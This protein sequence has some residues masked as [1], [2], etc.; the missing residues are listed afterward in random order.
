MSM[1][2]TTD[3]QPEAERVAFW[4]EVVCRSF[5]P[6]TV[7]TPDAEAF[8]GSVANDRLG[9]LQLSTVHAAA[10]RVRR[11]PRLVAEA[12][13][14]FVLLGLQ[15]LG[16]GVVT[17]DGRRAVIRPGDLVFY[18]AAR[19]YELWF[20]GEFEM[21][22]FMVP[23]RFLGVADADLHRV[24][25]TT[26]RPDAG[27]PA[28]ASP[29]L[30]RLTAA[31][32]AAGERLAA[33]ALNL[34]ESLVLDGTET[35]EPTLLLRIRTFIADHLG[36]RD[37]S[38]ATIAAAH[39][40]SVR[41]LHKLFSAEGVSVVR[42]IQQQRLAESRRDLGRTSATVAAIAH[43]WGFSD[44]AHFSRSFKAAYGVSPREWRI[45]SAPGPGGAD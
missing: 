9:R 1:V 37:L 22:V 33:S 6:L 25:A 23:R 4:H 3:T 7:A 10:Q 5:V 32:G 11:T 41:Y 13:D 43:R 21:K 30:A 34:L 12:G 35:P 29:F 27:V 8:S 14:E 38:P 2:L 42:W 19:P 44:A 31:E 28:L 18:D 20:P 39:R 15:T 36:E 26:L 24:T 40:I 16:P 45:A 17:Q